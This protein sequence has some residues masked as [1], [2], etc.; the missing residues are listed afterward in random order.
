MYEALLSF[1]PLILSHPFNSFAPPVFS[2]K[3]QF[4]YFTMGGFRGRS[5]HETAH[6]QFAPSTLP[7]LMFSIKQK[8]SYELKKMSLYWCFTRVSRQGGR[9]KKSCIIQM[10]NFR[11]IKVYLIM[12]KK[13]TCA[14]SRMYLVCLED[15][16]IKS[17]SK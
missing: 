10:R 16:K 6:K 12:R 1:T 14:I 3:Q 17:N 11:N 8:F 4:S 7:P 9:L 2:L 13:V 5:G 15:H